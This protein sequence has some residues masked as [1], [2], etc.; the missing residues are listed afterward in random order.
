[1]VKD[2]VSISHFKDEVI[3]KSKKGPE[4]KAYFALA[5]IVKFEWRE[6]FKARFGLAQVDLK[7]QL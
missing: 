4:S 6:G 2:I 3:V 7:T 5:F 1:M